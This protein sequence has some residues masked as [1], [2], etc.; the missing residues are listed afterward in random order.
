[1]SAWSQTASLD[2][3]GFHQ[4]AEASG[5]MVNLLWSNSSIGSGGGTNL[6]A[7]P[8]LSV[9]G[10][11]GPNVTIGG[12]VGFISVSGSANASVMST[13]VPPTTG[14]STGRDFPDSTAIL[15]SPRLGAVAMLGERAAFWLRGGITYFH[16][17]TETKSTIVTTGGRS[18]TSTTTV[19]TDGTA[20]TLD[21][22][23]VLLP[24]DHVGLTLG[25]VLDIGLGGSSE[26][27]QS[28]AVTTAG[29]PALDV[30]TSNYGAAAGLLVF[31]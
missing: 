23:V 26:T 7:M 3:G 17:T 28:P 31:F 9:D 20:L 13:G 25:P 14:T 8:R 29:S 2:S 11:V 1:V 5:T 4:E 21:P 15:F 12:S 6:F 19:T 16:S 27:T 18:T 10:F 30:K 24:A 22:V